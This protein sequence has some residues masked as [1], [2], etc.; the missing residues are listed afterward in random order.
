MSDR[1]FSPVK[2]AKIAEALESGDKGK[3]DQAFR[4]RFS[5][6]PGKLCVEDWLKEQDVLHENLL[7]AQQAVNDHRH[8]CT[9]RYSNGETCLSPTGYGDAQCRACRTQTD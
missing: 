8:R 6:E 4:E 9:H 1:P 2:D 7:K 5:P 3:I